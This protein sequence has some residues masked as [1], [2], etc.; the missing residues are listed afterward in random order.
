MEFA[1]NAALFFS[2][3]PEVF[4][5]LSSSFDYVKMDHWDGA[6]HPLIGAPTT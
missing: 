3:I 2:R 4:L 6:S 1:T 5:S